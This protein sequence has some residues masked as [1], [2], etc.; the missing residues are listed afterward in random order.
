M[1]CTFA[2]LHQVTVNI[3]KSSGIPKKQ[4][5]Y[6]W[7]TKKI[8]PVLQHPFYA[9][10]RGV[11]SDVFQVMKVEALQLAVDRYHG[12]LKPPEL[13]GHGT[14]AILNIRLGHTYLKKNRK[15]TS[16]VGNQMIVFATLGTIFVIWQVC[17]GA[18][19][20]TSICARVD[21]NFYWGWASY[22]WKGI[23]CNG[24]LHISLLFGFMT[25]PYHKEAMRV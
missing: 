10:P 19:R 21:N 5:L 1:Q 16:W 18:E 4:K 3:Q 2:K 8:A 15:P 12:K 7:T 13:F 17:P 14:N 24:S 11:H 25:V 6:S 9:S 20:V 22:S 23:P